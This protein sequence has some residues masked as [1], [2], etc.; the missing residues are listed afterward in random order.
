MAAAA[1]RWPRDGEA[2]DLLDK[3]ASAPVFRLCLPAPL[4]L[5]LSVPGCFFGMPAAGAPAALML[6]LLAGGEGNWPTAAWIWTWLLGGAMLSVHMTLLFGWDERRP[7]ATTALAAK[8]VY[9]VA[10]VVCAPLVAVASAYLLGLPG[11]GAANAYLL[12]WHAAIGPVLALKQA[13]RRRRP[14][15][16]VHH[17]GGD[18]PVRAL[19]AIGSIVSHDA[20]ASFPSGDAAGAVAFALPLW[21]CAGLWKA[22]VACVILSCCGRLYWHAHHLLDVVVG[23]LIAFAAS[24]AVEASMTGRGGVCDAAWWHPI[25]AQIAVLATVKA[26]RLDAKLAQTVAAAAAKKGSR[27]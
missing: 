20:N 14:V 6:A 8:T 15:A 9:S 13:A 25:I 22:A 12:I 11:G 2:L 27:R 21:R 5:V 26:L 4:E 19:G 16:A 17:P 3:R 23:C 7:A 24:L 18:L 1:S 10:S